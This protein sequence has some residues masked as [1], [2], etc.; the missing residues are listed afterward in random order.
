MAAETFKVTFKWDDLRLLERLGPK[1]WKRI[2]FASVNTINRTLKSAQRAV[3]LHVLDTF[4]VRN[5]PFVT[6]EAAI[7][8]PF[9]SVGQ[10]RP[11]GEISVGKKRRFLLAGFE[12]GILRTPFTRGAKSVAV[13]VDARP[14]PT[15]PV[16]KS[17]YVSELGL[18]RPKAT[19]TETRRAR[20]QGTTGRTWEGKD[21]T[22]LI[23]GE[24]IFQRLRGA[25]SRVLYVFTAPF[26]LRPALK[27]VETV[28]STAL[29]VFPEHL[30][31]EINDA[32]NRR[33]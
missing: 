8:K 25:A 18:R 5:T 19:T 27:F 29:R 31:D 17:L 14:T 7:I 21:G 24:G 13:P 3:Q 6:R 33:R 30:R 32:L 28:R 10:A 1:S 22:Y 20:R 4:T 2:A 26:R 9:A 23:P 16:P 11:Y 15:S 12:E